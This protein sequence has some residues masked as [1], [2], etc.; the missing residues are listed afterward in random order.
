MKGEDRGGIENGDAGMMNYEWGIMEREDGDGIGKRRRGMM[1][2]E[3]MIGRFRK[4]GAP[5]LSLW[6]EAARKFS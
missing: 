4:K 1:N 5:L 3:C 2:H 6:K